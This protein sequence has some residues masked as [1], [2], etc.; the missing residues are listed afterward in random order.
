MCCGSSPYRR[1]PCPGSAPWSARRTRPNSSRLPARLL[2]LAVSALLLSDGGYCV[3]IAG[4]DPG[5]ATGAALVG[6]MACAVLFGAATLHPSVAE[7]GRRDDVNAGASVIRV[8]A[9]VVFAVVDPV[10]GAL[11]EVFSRREAVH[12]WADDVVPALLVM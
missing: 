4:G 2:A 9:F 8:V 6:W 10:I 12:S 11:V 5:T 7:V 3:T 1:A